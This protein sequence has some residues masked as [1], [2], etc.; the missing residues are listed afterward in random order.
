VTPEVRALSREECLEKLRTHSVGRVSATENALPVI[1]PVNYVVDG[2]A[3]V[4]RTAAGGLLDRVCHSSVVAF[5]VDEIAADGMSG[6]SVLIVGVAD[7]LD[8][9]EQVRA[10]SRRLVS[11]AGPGRDHFVRVTFGQVTGREI[12]PTLRAVNGLN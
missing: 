4:F 5:E 12:H 1:V 9:G 6:W 8:E 3:V 10:S 7:A 2:S 11:A